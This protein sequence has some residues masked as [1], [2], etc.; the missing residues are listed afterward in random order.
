M[1]ILLR[2]LGPDHLLQ[3]IKL[4]CLFSQLEFIV[5]VNLALQLDHVGLDLVKLYF[6]I[7]ACL[8]SMLELGG[9]LVNFES[10]LA[11]LFP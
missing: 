11:Y 5:P 1:L 10:L 3:L 4:F 2:L 7:V 9:Q 6:E 8:I